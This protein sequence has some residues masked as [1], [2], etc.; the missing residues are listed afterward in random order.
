MEAL[1]L[2]QYGANGAM[3]EMKRPAPIALVQSRWN[4]SQVSIISIQVKFD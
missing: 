4:H 2:K 3:L 1:N